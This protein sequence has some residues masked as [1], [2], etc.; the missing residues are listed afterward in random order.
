MR[1]PGL[2]AGYGRA[3]P[4]PRVLLLSRPGCHLCEE[5]AE[6][7]ARVCGE[8]RVSWEE[9][10]IAGDPELEPRYGDHVPVTFVDGS[11]HGLWYVDEQRLRRALTRRRWKRR[12]TRQ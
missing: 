3:V 2:V 4:E 6:V 1:R 11:E 7:V 5:A 10:S 12:A 8:L 9:R